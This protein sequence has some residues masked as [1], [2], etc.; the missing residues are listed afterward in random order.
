MSVSPGYKYVCRFEGG[1]QWYM[2]EPKDVISSILLKIKNENN[3]LVSIKGQSIS[4]RLP[5]KEN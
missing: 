3:E 2:M 5:I 1:I 4:F